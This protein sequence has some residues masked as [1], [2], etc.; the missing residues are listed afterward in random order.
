MTEKTITY[1]QGDATQPV[2]EGNKIIVHVCN[3]IGGWGRG[4]VLALS[5]RWKS[6]E[7]AYRDWYKSGEGFEL[8]AT[9]LVKVEDDLWVGNMIG[10]HKIKKAQDG[11]PPIRYEAV[12]TAL[13]KIAGDATRLNASVHMPKIGAGL[14]GGDWQT[15]E[16][17]IQEELANQGISVV[18]YNF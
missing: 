11:T 3:D 1:L 15:I 2:G 10:Q 5:K 9:Q 8:G 6:P 16:G 12:R 18:V 17:I 7:K 4:F 14:A 13:G